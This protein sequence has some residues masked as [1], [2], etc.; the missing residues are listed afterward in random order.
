[1]VFGQNRKGVEVLF[2]KKEIFFN[3]PSLLF[4]KRIII[5]GAGKVGQD[6]IAQLAKYQKIEIVAWVDAKYDACSF[7]YR[8]VE[9]V[10]S[11]NEKSFDY[12]VISVL[13]KEKAEEIK[14]QLLRMN[15]DKNKVLWEAPLSTLYLEY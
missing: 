4:G 5:Y 11:I 3:T 1:M 10:Q 13:D 6:Y 14:R 9:S 8:K 15:I 7:E 12:I 2:W